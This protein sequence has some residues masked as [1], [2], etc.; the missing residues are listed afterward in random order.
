MTHLAPHIQK[1]NWEKLL[2][3]SDTLK[4]FGAADQDLLYDALD[5]YMSKT[6]YNDDIQA[7][8]NIG[9]VQEHN[10]VLIWKGF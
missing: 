3:I 1:L 7:L 8:I 2:L 9:F 6:E 4:R 10:R 5:Q